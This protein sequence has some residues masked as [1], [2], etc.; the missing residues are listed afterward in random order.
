MIRSIKALVFLALLAFAQTAHAQGIPIKSGG[1][2]N[3]AIVDADGNL[4]VN[5]PTT[6][7]NAGYVKAADAS[8][9]PI[10]VLA[11]D[12]TNTLLTGRP[13]P[14]FYD[15]IESTTIDVRKWAQPATTM[16]MSQA[17]GQITMNAGNAT[18]SGNV[19]RLTSWQAFP[20][21]GVVGCGAYWT[22]R[23]S[24]ATLPTNQVAEMGL[25]IHTS[26]TAATS[27]IYFQTTTSGT[28]QAVRTFNSVDSTAVVT[29]SNPSKLHAARIIR[30]ETSV[31]FFLDDVQVASFDMVGGASGGAVNDTQYLP[32][33]FRIYNSGVASAANQLILGPATVFCDVDDTLGYG[34][35]M[36]RMGSQIHVANAS[37][38]ATRGGTQNPNWSNSAAPASATLSNTAAG[39]T[40][41]GGQYQFAATATNETDWALFAYQNPTGQN[42]YV[43]SVTADLCITGAASANA[44][45]FFW[46]AATSSTAVSLATSDSIGAATIG[47]RRL[48]L[49]SMGHLA[50][51]AQGT[52]I[53]PYMRTFDPPLVVEPTRF[54]HIILKSLNQAATASL[55]YRGTVG[56]HGYT[57]P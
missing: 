39:Y 24:Q 26:T 19:A 47:P 23:F 38:T 16:T 34:P 57:G 25:V 48:P 18:A 43:T 9:D 8:G 46:A 13:V 29:L 54:F 51:A 49:F 6:A 42:L 33:S 28:F 2:S 12:A 14:S 3:T 56:I 32:L 7:A 41:L 22:F 55:V 15:P 37:N 10:E 44:T 45:N 30:G 17:T 5:T 20:M 21:Y 36:A 52:C 40:T 31:T 11:R 4:Y 27:G 1:S 53:G 50:A 35:R